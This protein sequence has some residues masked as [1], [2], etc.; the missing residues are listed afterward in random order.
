M[1]KFFYGNPLMVWAELF[2]GLA[3]SIVKDQHQGIVNG[4]DRQGFDDSMNL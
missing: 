1:Q 3:P 2:E 4:F